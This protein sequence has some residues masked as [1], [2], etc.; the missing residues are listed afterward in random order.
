MLPLLATARRRLRLLRLL[1]PG[2][3]HQQ[4]HSTCAAGNSSTTTTTT[5]TTTTIPNHSPLDH[6]PPSLAAALPHLQWEVGRFDPTLPIESAATP[7]SSW[8]T[9]RAI[10]DLEMASVFREHPLAVGSALQIP[11]AGD[12]FTGNIG[13]RHPFIVLRDQEGAVRAFYNVCRH[14]GMRAVMGDCGSLGPAGRIACP[15][16]GWE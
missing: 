10:H 4:P 5:T 8:F 12:Y 15:Y 11:A 1:V 16:H 6:P 9:D 13:R 14:K 2:R 7:P 3:A